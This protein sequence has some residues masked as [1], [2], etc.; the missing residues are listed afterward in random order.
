MENKDYRIKA[1]EKTSVVRIPT[2]TKDA[3][4]EII[5]YRDL[6][7]SLGQIITVLQR[8]ATEELKNVKKN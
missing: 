7:E 8:Q 4:Q 2:K 3:L 1:Y 6:A 5:A